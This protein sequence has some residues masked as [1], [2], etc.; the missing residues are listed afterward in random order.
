[1]RREGPRGSASQTPKVGTTVHTMMDGGEGAKMVNMM[2][3]LAVKTSAEGAKR[4]RISE[5]VVQVACTVLEGQRN[6]CST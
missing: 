2:K 3:T 1:M 6:R 4:V 5:A